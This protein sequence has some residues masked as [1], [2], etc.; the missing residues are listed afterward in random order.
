VT[1]CLCFSLRLGLPFTDHCLRLFLARKPDRNFCLPSVFSFSLNMV[2][3]S[4]Q[5]KGK[6]HPN[7]LTCCFTISVGRLLGKWFVVGQTLPCDAVHVYPVI[8]SSS[9]FFVVFR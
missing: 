2:L 9:S 1:R 6:W 8:S 5:I 4:Y 7:R 3:W